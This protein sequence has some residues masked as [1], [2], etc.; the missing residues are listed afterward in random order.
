MLVS[1]ASRGRGYRG[2]GRGRGGRFGGSDD[3]EFRWTQKKGDSDAMKALKR[4]RGQD[5]EHKEK[6]AMKTFV[7]LVEE[8]YGKTTKDGGATG[9]AT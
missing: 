8:M 4:L 7:D 2:R 9:A 6:D 1:G 5:T 3:R